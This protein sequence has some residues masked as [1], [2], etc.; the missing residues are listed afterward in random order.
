M[1]LIM[2]GV[3]HDSFTGRRKGQQLLLLLLE[4]SLPNDSNVRSARAGQGRA[5]RGEV[6]GGDDT[7]SGFFTLGTRVSRQLTSVG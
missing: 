6:R 1:T 7:K 2:I 3:R 4:K 5:V